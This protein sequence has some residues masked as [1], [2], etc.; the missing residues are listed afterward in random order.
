[1]KPPKIRILVADDHPVVRDGIVSLVEVEKDMCI[2]A[3][4]G[5]GK[6][7]VDLATKLLP[8][9]LLLDLRMP[10][11][12]GLEVIAQ[13]QSLHVS[14]KVIVLTTFDSE[15]DVHLALKAGA[16][17]YLLKDAPRP[18]LL[19]TIRQ[20]HGGKTCIPPRIGQK[21]VENMSRPVL[22]ARELD[23]LKLVAEG[24]SNK[25]I[26]D[27]LGIAEGTVKTHVKSLLKKLQAPGRTAAVREAVHRG[28]VQLA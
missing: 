1:M 11:M 16:R 19:D 18:V 15:Q 12:D 25:D 21:L 6:E 3:Q 8:D 23:I 24:K 9:I 2:V 20:V 28:L 14:S 7:A 13:L 10:R 4:A 27:Q 17:G 5:D 26:G 22:S